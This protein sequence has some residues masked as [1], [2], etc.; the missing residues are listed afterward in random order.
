MVKVRIAP[1]PTGSIHIGLARTALYNWLFARHNNGKFVLRIEDTDLARSSEEST[2]I[3]IEGFR[4]L[5]I[6]WDEGPYF[7]SKR[8]E[9]YQKYAEQ[10]IKD[11]KAYYCYCTPQRLAEERKKR[12]KEGKGWKYDRKCLNLTPQEIKELEE[13]KTPKVIRFL[14]PPEEISYQDI[15]HGEIKKSYRDIEDFVLLRSD[16]TPTYNFACVIDD[17]EM[18][19]THVVR[20][21]EHINNT[22]KQILLY[23]AFNWKIPQFAHLPLILG[24]DRKKLSK[25]HGAVSLLEYKKQ[26]ILPEALLNYLALLG[27]SPK[28]NREIVSLKEMISLFRLEDI[29]KSNAVFDFKKLEWMNGEYMRMLPIEEMVKRFKNYVEE[30]K[31]IKI[32]MPYQKLKKIVE[33]TRERT[34]TLHEMFEMSSIFI[35]GEVKYEE[36]VIK[37]HFSDENIKKYLKILKERF[38]KIH[39]FT[40]EETEKVLREVAGELNLKAARLIHPLRVAV[41]GKKVG[42]PLFDVLELLGK[43]KVLKSIEKFC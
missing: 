23:R 27:W 39:N 11:K 6:D 24:E 40:K 14:V 36:E 20:A 17:H 31:G 26:G 30:F 2:R 34:R 22:F 1:S 3:I 13:K 42:P 9:I 29:N 8:F 16:G 10:L 35:T 28:E 25:R 12:E 7:Q 33:I 19:I 32:E 38:E 18:E 4:W 43:E 37:E 21:V 15:I 41:T 5:G